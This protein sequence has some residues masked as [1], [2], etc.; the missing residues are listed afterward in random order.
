MYFSYI[1]KLPNNTQEKRLAENG[2]LI[3][4]SLGL[5][6]VRIKSDMISRFERLSRK[7]VSSL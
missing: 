3:L 4:A 2:Q 1:T 5:L 7:T 6:S